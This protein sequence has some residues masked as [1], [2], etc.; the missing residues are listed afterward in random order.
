MTYMNLKKKSNETKKKNIRNII[1]FFSI[2]IKIG[3][4]ARRNRQ[5]HRMD[6]MRKDPSYKDL[7]VEVEHKTI[8]DAH[9]KC[10]EELLDAAREYRVD[11]GMFD[12]E[13]SAVY[14]HCKD[15]CRELRRVDDP[16]ADIPSDGDEQEDKEN[17][18][19]SA[20]I[21]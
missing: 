6:C 5:S 4:K 7:C 13:A 17:N 2:A 9:Q 19:V 3:N 20:Q 18:V 12:F 11:H 8:L 1:Y 16:S 21:L 14:K 15:L 10:R